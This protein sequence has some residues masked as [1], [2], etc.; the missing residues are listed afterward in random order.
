MNSYLISR[1]RHHGNRASYIFWV[2]LALFTAL[3]VT[4]QDFA[5]FDSVQVDNVLSVDELQVSSGAFVD[6]DLIFDSNPS[7]VLNAG[8][9]LTRGS[10]LSERNKFTGLDLMNPATDNVLASAHRRFTVTTEP[11]KDVAALFNGAESSH[12][13]LQPSETLKLRIDFSEKQQSYIVY[14]G[15]NLYL[16]AYHVQGF[17]VSQSQSTH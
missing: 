11:V 6:G 12:L 17:K 7:K 14:G 3:G 5:Q 4:A 16:S 8:N 15:G 10:Y 1:I 2:Q 13:V 9:L